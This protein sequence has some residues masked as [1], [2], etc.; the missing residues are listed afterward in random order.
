VRIPVILG[1]ATLG[2]ALLAPP[3]PAQTVLFDAGVESNNG[4]PF[5][6]EDAR[7]QQVYAGNR[8][9]TAVFVTAITIFADERNASGFFGADYRLRLATTK[10]AVGGLSTVWDANLGADV[11]TVFSGFL[12]GPVATAYTF[13][14]SSPF[15]FDP[16]RG[17]LLLDVTASNQSGSTTYSWDAVVN[18]TDMSRMTFQG[19]DASN[20]GLV[21]EFRTTVTPEPVSA[22]LLAS[23]LLG[24]ATARRRRRLPRA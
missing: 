22:L 19:R 1:V 3:A 12:S 10:A 14:L 6:R 18:A 23:G 11:A 5:G 15:W 16:T 4:H 24:V 13:A 21:T 20:I 9:T 17:N 8:F 2:L 7:Y